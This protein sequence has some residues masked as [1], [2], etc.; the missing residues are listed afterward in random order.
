MPIDPGPRRRF[1][2]QAASV[3]AACAAV[4]LGA[5]GADEPVRRHGRATLV[6]ADAMP[7][8]AGSLPVLEN[9]IF[10]YPFVGT[11]VFLIRLNGP[12]EGGV[13][14]G[15][16]VV[17]FSAICAH[18]LAYPTREFSVI[19][20]RAKA[21]GPNA[22]GEVIHC[23]AEHSQYDP[24][25]QARVVGGPAPHALAAIVLEHDAA[26]DQLTAVGTRGT[27][28]FDKFFAKYEVRLAMEH[29]GRE[30][31]PVEGSCV[32][33]PLSNFCRQQVVC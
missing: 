9:L 32:V 28:L 10:H 17:A 14:P 18:Q 19:S 25:H 30:R 24:A 11:P 26:T 4:P 7:I 6:G 16:S 20:F 2:E 1:L 15:R 3:G 21:G 12:A 27:E 22:R 33:K 29:R 5:W 13:G 31:R 23:C 8:K